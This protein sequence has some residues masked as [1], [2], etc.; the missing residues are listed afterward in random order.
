MASAQATEEL[1][2]FAWSLNYRRVVLASLDVDVRDQLHLIV[3]EVEEDGH[4]HQPM[5]TGN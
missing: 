3:V 4:Q 1:G 5:Q 2:D